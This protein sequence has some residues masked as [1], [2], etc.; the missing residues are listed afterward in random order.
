[1]LKIWNKEKGM[2]KIGSICVAFLF[3]LCLTSCND[4]GG[5]ATESNYK[6]AFEDNKVSSEILE[7][8]KELNSDNMIQFFTIKTEDL[9]VQVFMM[10]DKKQE[11][12][13]YVVSRMQ[14][15]GTWISEVPKW[16]KACVKKKNGGVV[17]ITEDSKGVFYAVWWDSTL[18]EQKLLRLYENGVVE[19]LDID[20]AR[21]MNKGYILWSVSLINDNKMILQFDKDFVAEKKDEFEEKDSLTH[22]V[23][24]NLAEEKVG[25]EIGVMGSLNDNFDEQGI[26]YTADN[27]QNMILGR[28]ISS[29]ISDR[30]IKCKADFPV[31]SVMDIRDDYGYCKTNDGIYGGKL[32]AAEWSCI[33][34]SEDMIKYKEEKKEVEGEENT[35]Y[36]IDSDSPVK[37]IMKTPGNDRE[38]YCL[39]LVNKEE[40][41]YQWVHYYDKP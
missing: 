37:V 10:K 33:I 29:T 20:E 11:Q 4:T 16:N 18:T 36:M 30:V 40:K 12:I 13:R 8:P 25:E 22:A 21:K 6:G 34:P 17:Y 31:S 19:E 14:P 24:Y 5:V 3:L 41:Q 32:E 35:T 27:L 28:K 26:C 7:G 9:P 15:D 23:E 1:M 38:F 39:A 2:K